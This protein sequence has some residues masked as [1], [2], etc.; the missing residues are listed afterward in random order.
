MKVIYLQKITMHSNVV[1]FES[2]KEQLLRQ[3]F[4][5][6][7]TL[8]YPL[9]KMNQTHSDNIHLINPKTL[10]KKITTI[11]NTDCLIT[12]SKN[13]ILA[14]RTADCMPIIISHP[15][16]YLCSI[17]SGRKGTEKKLLQKAIQTLSKKTQSNKDFSIWFGPHIC[18]HCYEINSKT[19]EYYNL[20]KNNITQLQNELNLSENHLIVSPYCTCCNNTMYFSYRKNNQ[21]KRRNF[22]FCYL[23]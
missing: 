1:F 12:N 11:L 15:S 16:G 21:T 10:Q 19:R 17:H 9:V 7:K 14:V 18:S 20:Q 23:K 4:D 2:N 3:T 5:H 22:F 8:S 13:I 6:I